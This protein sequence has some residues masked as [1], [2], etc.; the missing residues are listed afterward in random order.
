M[1]NTLCNGIRE[2]TEHMEEL[3]NEIK[4]WAYAEAACG[5]GVHLCDISP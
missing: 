1:H 5:L 3:S 4:L 2:Y